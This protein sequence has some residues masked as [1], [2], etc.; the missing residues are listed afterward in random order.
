MFDIHP[1]G[2]DVDTR[3]STSETRNLNRSRGGRKYFH[4]YLWDCHN[5]Q[6][7]DFKARFFPVEYS[8]ACLLFVFEVYKVNFD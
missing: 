8:F 4:N 1:Y 2:S 6:F 5:R 3:K 7:Q